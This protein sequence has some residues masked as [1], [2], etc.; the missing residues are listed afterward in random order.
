MRKPTATFSPCFLVT[1]CALAASGQLLALPLPTL[2]RVPQPLPR[3]HLP[4]PE[5][6]PAN[7]SFTAPSRNACASPY[8]S[9][10]GAE[11]GVYAYW[12]LCEKGTGGM[13]ADYVGRYDLVLG[14]DAWGGGTITG[15]KAGPV[16]DGETA[17]QVSTAS[18]YIEAQNL[19]LN[20]HAGTLAAWV[21][22]DTQ[23]AYPVSMV[24]FGS[25]GGQSAIT[26]RSASQGSDICFSATF[27]NAQGLVSTVQDAC[28]T[29]AN[30]WHRV[31]FSWAGGTLSLAVDG[32]AKASAAYSGALDNSV[33]YYRLFPDCCNTGKQMTLAKVVLSNQAWTAAQVRLDASPQPVVAPH[34]G[35]YVSAQALGTIHADVLG[36]QDNNANLTQAAPKEALLEGLAAA[37]V[38]SVRY[39]SGTAGIEADAVD[40]RGRGSCSGVPGQT[41]PSPSTTSGNRLTTYLPEIAKALSLHSGYTVNYGSNPPYCDAG[42]DP[43]SN[44]S[45]LVNYAN[46]QQHD[47]IHYWEIGNEQYNG[48]SSELDLHPTPANGSSYAAYETVFY[49]QMKA[50]DPTIQIGIP[51]GLETYGWQS[52]WDFPAMAQAKYDAVVYH[53]YPVRD[54][55]TDGDTLYGDRV[56]SNMGRTRGALLSLQTELLNVGKDPSAIWVTEWDGDVGGD[57][58]SRQSLGAVAPLFAV[59]QLAE[60]MQAGVQYATWLAQGEGSACFLYNFDYSASSSYSWAPCGGSFLT[61]TGP[62]A[63]E[64]PVGFRP[65]DLSP[66]GH[67]FQLLAQSG[68]VTE[69]E[70]MVR[71]YTDEAAAPWLA[72]YGATHGNASAVI[73]INRDR[74]A[75][76]TVPVQLAAQAA[77]SVVQEWTYGLSQYNFAAKGLWGVGPAV[78]THGPW[79]G[80]YAAVLP[81]WSVTVLIFKQ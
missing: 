51:V 13:L 37:G 47:H 64:V 55:I 32:V 75:T 6:L 22:V 45:D 26:L 57:L 27:E 35:I 17:A 12:A 62:L 46:V 31:T 21:N 59:T 7:T 72:G 2:P 4:F 33:F 60:Y 49:N 80:E 5:A 30:S 44:G 38:R 28:T 29:R 16:Q 25:V 79:H 61:Y 65:G 71:T 69:G 39:A 20:T 9:F 19:P 15:G 73:L 23:G 40:W 54:P 58:W 3:G 67:A 34:G 77:G 18:S 74:D 76:H 43:T 78:S 66:A 52:S 53:N 8:D 68:F 1:L 10:Y 81:A 70:H 11:P 36:Y 14:Q 41:F 56:A 42:G 24:Y 63:G 50:Q 48:G